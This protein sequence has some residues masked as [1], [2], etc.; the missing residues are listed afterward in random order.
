M[1]HAEDELSIIIIIPFLS[2]FFKGGGREKISF[3]G[4]R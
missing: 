2:L 3:W 4:V 1:T